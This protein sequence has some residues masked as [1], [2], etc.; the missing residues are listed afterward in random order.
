MYNIAGGEGWVAIQSLGELWTGESWVFCSSWWVY[1]HMN[2]P[3]HLVRSKP[4]VFIVKKN[5]L[6][7]KRY[8]FTGWWK[9]LTPAVTIN[10]ITVESEEDKTTE[11]TLNVWLIDHEKRFIHPVLCNITPSLVAWGIYHVGFWLKLQ[12]CKKALI[13]RNIWSNGAQYWSEVSNPE[14]PGGPTGN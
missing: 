10:Y 8:R 2:V 14:I 5:V 11:E 3:L 12:K 13:I 4:N 9:C 1:Q 6:R 7:L